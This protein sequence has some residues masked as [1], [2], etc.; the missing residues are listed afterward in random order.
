MCVCASELCLARVHII[1]Y[2]SIPANHFKIFSWT[3]GTIFRDFQEFS[4][5]MAQLWS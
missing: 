3:L 2:I 5:M 4:G 1:L